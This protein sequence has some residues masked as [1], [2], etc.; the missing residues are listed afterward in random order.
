ME[1]AALEAEGLKE[2]GIQNPEDLKDPNKI[3]AAI[4]DKFG[5]ELGMEK[6]IGD[7]DDDIPPGLEEGEAKWKTVNAVDVFQQNAIVHAAIIRG[8]NGF[9]GVELGGRVQ[10]GKIQP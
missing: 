5:Q 3:A 2:I 6:A 7:A 8:R 1:S 10:V 9:D 4:E